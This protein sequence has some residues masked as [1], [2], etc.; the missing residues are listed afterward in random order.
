MSFP[1]KVLTLTKKIPKGKVTTYK[2]I[3]NR[4]G[5]NAYRAVGY[6]LKCN[7]H[8]IIIPCHRVV[9]SDGSLGGYNGILNNPKK[10]KLLQKEGITIKNNK[11]VDFEKVLFRF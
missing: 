10:I 8:P 6:A 3:A 9:S 4:L 1:N 11:I 7:E 5:T 2:I